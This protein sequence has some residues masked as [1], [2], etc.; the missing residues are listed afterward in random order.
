MVGGLS[1]SV[2]K[3]LTPFQKHKKEEEDKKR[4]APHAPLPRIPPTVST[5][6][7]QHALWIATVRSA[8]DALAASRPPQPATPAAD[9]SV[10]RAACRRGGGEA[11]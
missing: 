7:R 2:G 10:R 9:P 1:F 6:H 5:L 4:V 11:V 8:C 3:K